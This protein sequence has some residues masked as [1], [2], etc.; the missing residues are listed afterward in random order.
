MPKPRA[1]G[2]IKRE[3]LSEGAGPNARRP[4]GVG[5]GL[6]AGV[7]GLLIDAVVHQQLGDQG[8]QEGDGDPK[9]KAASRAV[10]R[11]P[12]AQ[13]QGRQR[14]GELNV[15]GKIQFLVT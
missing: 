1:C 11:P 7:A 10:K 5:G 4:P 13:R 15:I 6:T 12:K 8:G 14:Q 9:A 2:Q 3:H